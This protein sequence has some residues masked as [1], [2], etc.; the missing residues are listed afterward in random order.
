M[1]NPIEILIEKIE[2]YPA[3]TFEA[4]VDEYVYDGKK[5]FIVYIAENQNAI[6]S[7]KKQHIKESILIQRKDDTT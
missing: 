5:L 2:K 4:N 7:F 6:N 3:E 1:K